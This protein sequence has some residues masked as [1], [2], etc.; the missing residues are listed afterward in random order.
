MET[1][2]SISGSSGLGEGVQAHL[3]VVGEGDADQ[4]EGEIIAAV[5][6]E[7]GHGPRSEDFG[8]EIKSGGVEKDAEKLEHEPELV[9][10]VDVHVPVEEAP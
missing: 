6:L 8:N 1:G 3:L 10:R 9:G 4:D 7:G 5:G 2:V